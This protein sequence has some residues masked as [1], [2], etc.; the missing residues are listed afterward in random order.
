MDSDDGIKYREF[1]D[2]AGRANNI[3]DWKGR[4]FEYYR[5]ISRYRRLAGIAGSKP[6]SILDLGCGDGYLSC[7]LAGNGHRVDALDISSERLAKFSDH[8]KRLGIRQICGS[9]LEL[10]FPGTCDIVIMSE[11][12][13]HLEDYKPVLHKAAGILRKG[14]RLL[15]S[16]PYREKVN[17]CRCPY[18]LREFNIY[19]HVHSF[20]EAKL[21]AAAEEA[22]LSVGRMFTMNNKLTAYLSRF[23]PVRT[24]M[25]YILCDR[26][27]SLLS[28][29]TDTH[30][31]VDMI[32]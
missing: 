3:W 14:G 11:V 32:K 24:Y 7:M 12:I 16:V 1:Y 18:C 30:I 28:K 26:V 8:A 13:E 21:K 4:K 20:D 15:V 10:D 19:G 9:I 27:F 25:L 23:G 6:S 29:K 2:E 22:G 5:E 17:V 31:I